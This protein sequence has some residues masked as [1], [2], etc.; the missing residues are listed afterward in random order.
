MNNILSL[1]L[2]FLL[3]GSGT[4]RIYSNHYREAG[5]FE[6]ELNPDST[7]EAHVGFCYSTLGKFHYI[8]PNT[9]L[10][11]SE[12]QR[13][14][15][16]VVLKRNNLGYRLILDSLP[17]C[18]YDKYTNGLYYYAYCY[19]DS[20]VL[21][22][23]DKSVIIRDSVTTFSF[24]SKKDLLVRVHI[25]WRSC[26]EKSFFDFIIPYSQTQ[27]DYHLLWKPLYT[28]MPSLNDT[29]EFKNN[30]LFYPKEVITFERE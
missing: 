19:I 23:P 27:M 24:S 30:N 25:A 5:L 16:P 3:V 11:K 15:L 17:L 6:I 26:S 18:F 28:Q 20:I 12:F 1:L 8:S 2:V 10:L 9:I 4:K 13:D 14:N 7:F 21:M 22:M 29:F